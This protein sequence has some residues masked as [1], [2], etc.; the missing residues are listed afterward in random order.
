MPQRRDE[1]DPDPFYPV[2]AALSSGKNGRFLRLD[3]HYPNVRLAAA[4]NLG[5]T[6]NASGGSGALHESVDPA[7]R[8]PPNLLGHCMVSGELAGV[9]EL[10]GPKGAALRGDAAGRFDH[11][12][13]QRLV[14]SAAEARHDGQLGAKGRHVISLFRTEGIR[15]HD[16][17]RISARGANQRE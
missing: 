13:R 15:G 1:T 11:S 4:Q 6:A 10:I 3:R 16:A 9:V 14:H 2:N 8:L 7:I 17:E 12:A 5:N